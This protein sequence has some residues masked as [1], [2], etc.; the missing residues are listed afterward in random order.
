MEVGFV[1]VALIV[2]LGLIWFWNSIY[3]IKEWERGVVLR[4]GELAQALEL[5]AARK[6]VAGGLLDRP[7]VVGEV[8]IHLACPSYRIRGR[9]S[10]RSAMMFFRISVV[11]PSIEFARARRKR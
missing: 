10:T 7:L 2:G 9:P 6:Q 4:L 8:E 5:E 1:G 11:P 3:I